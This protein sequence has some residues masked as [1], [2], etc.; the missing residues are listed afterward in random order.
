MASWGASKP[1]QFVTDELPVC[2]SYQDN[3]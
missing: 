3:L 2:F 1:K